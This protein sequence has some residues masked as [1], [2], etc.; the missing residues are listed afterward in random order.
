MTSGMPNENRVSVESTETVTPPIQDENPVADNGIPPIP[1]PMGVRTESRDVS[2][3][4]RNTRDSL[5][6]NVSMRNNTFTESERLFLERLTIDGTD[7]DVERALQTVE[8]QDLFFEHSSPRHL[9]RSD[10]AI[11]LQINPSTSS[12]PDDATRDAEATSVSTSERRGL[13][14]VATNSLT[15][16]DDSRRFSSSS[17]STPPIPSNILGS[18]RRQQ[19]L[20]RR[21]SDASLNMANLWRAH[22]TGLA[23]TSL[24]SQKSL[25]RRE[26]SIS[27]IGSNMSGLS[28]LFG[29]R[30][31]PGA[32]QQDVR[33][34]RGG[35]NVPHKGR[36]E[37]PIPAPRPFA[38][39]MIPRS[40]LHRS[41]SIT[42]AALNRNF[43][44]TKSKPSGLSN[45]QRAKSFSKRRS[46]TFH[47]IDE[48]LEFDKNLE[49]TAITPG[50]AV[51]TESKRSQIVRRAVS[52]SN[53]AKSQEPDEEDA[54]DQ[55]PQVL[56][57]EVSTSSIPSLHH[58]TPIRQDSISSI[59]SL[60]HGNPLRDSMSIAGHS[61]SS[62]PSLHQAN[63]LGDSM[64]VMG[65]SI[66]SIPSLHQAVPIRRDS[67][68]SATT[69]AS[70]RPSNPLRQES[71]SS[72]P[73]LH[74]GN[75]VRQESM[76]SFP[77]LHHG[78]PLRQE[79]TSSFPSIHHGKPIR[80]DS[81]ASSMAPDA[82]TQDQRTRQFGVTDEMAAAWIQLSSSSTTL[83]ASQTQP[84][85]SDDVE[86]PSAPTAPTISTALDAGEFV[87]GA[88]ATTADSSTDDASLLTSSSTRQAIS[89]LVGSRP[90]PVFLRQASNNVY[91]GEGVEVTE[92]DD[93]P[94]EGTLSETDSYYY[95]YQ[96]DNSVFR[97][98]SLFSQN[99]GSIRTAG[100]FDDVS[101]F[102]TYGQQQRTSDV[103]RDIRRSLSDDNLSHFVGQDKEFLLQIPAS[104][105]GTMT[106]TFVDDMSDD[107]Y[108]TGWEME[109]S[110]RFDAWNILQDEYANGYGGAGTLGFKIL[111]TS[112]SDEAAQPH[113]LSPPLMESLQAFL[114]QTKS[115]EN[116][117]MKYSMIRDGA[118]LQT[119]L[120]RARGIQYSILAVETID[121]EVFG[122]FTG[123]A[124]RK[125][126]NYFGTG[127]AFLWRMRHSRLD[128][129]NGILDQAKKE[130][131]IDV[132]P[133]TGENDF[134]QLC[135]HDRIAVGGGIPEENDSAEKKTQTEP[136]SNPLV[137][138][139]HD[140]GLGLALRSDLL[141][142]SSSPC[143][144]FGSPS[145]CK[146]KPSGE[147]F[148]VVNV[149]LWAMTPCATEEDAEKLELGK[150]FL[151]S[152]SR[153]RNSLGLTYTY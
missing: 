100:S 38:R 99:Y 84:S 81:V 65:Q 133:Y 64:S 7:E 29:N 33:A 98:A 55:H 34:D 119:L 79:S 151:G 124:W 50:N 11:G 45:K 61:T 86:I 147:R 114:P 25:L 52:D 126:W 110:G 152:A 150:L 134:I 42:I 115:G 72:F 63:P 14:K 41:K 116:F 109:S 16:S 127:D 19:V 89:G 74:H 145:L 23:V 9:D 4:S 102:S 120:K 13:D 128:A 97:T 135:T 10:S 18:E 15:T 136:L 57:R 49:S 105:D 44:K 83:D 77:S 94:I 140:W 112:A 132:Y 70:L 88:T 130:S 69:F 75:P 103:F 142:G 143:L 123:Q 141:Q 131:E 101:F 111:G 90:K 31:H 125:S 85:L 139:A 21:R 1:R 91:Q 153:S 121:G 17:S 27:S 80:Q 24:G 36:P 40:R 138:H 118:S 3:C 59:P 54:F 26:S 47:S 48:E 6:R 95:P 73:S 12:A 96:Q 106:D 58:G 108:S 113:V 71:V 8:D 56:E 104:A 146:S 82:T 93:R 32:T 22:E 30:P 20:Q 67:T 149:E 122:S 37:R 148:E 35:K 137:D 144:T 2:V 28:V 51:E 117:F 92:L 78:N 68:A 129:T 87:D 60:H 66:S 46:V 5:R 76:S 107:G 62:I 39:P 53:I 43:A